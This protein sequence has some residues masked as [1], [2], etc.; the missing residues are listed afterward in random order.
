MEKESGILDGM[1][2]GEA[3]MRETGISQSTL[4][5]WRARGLP[6]IRAGNV[7]WYPASG[8]RQWILDHLIVE[9]PQERD[10]A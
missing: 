5:R 3:I 1:M 2:L 6:Y 9:T 8:V 4:Y 7:V 10:A